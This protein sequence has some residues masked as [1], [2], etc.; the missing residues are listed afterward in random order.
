M[1]T[2]TLSREDGRIGE[3]SRDLEVLGRILL[4]AI[5]VS[6]GV[7]KLVGWPAV[8]GSIG[9]KGVPFPEIAGVA[10]IVLELCGALALVTGW[11]AR[12]A[13]V[14]LAVFTAAA[15]VL[16][17]PFWAVE[18]AQYMNQFNHFMK[19]VAIIGGLFIVAA[20]RR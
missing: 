11:G 19:N 10:V 20:R 1:Q 2:R 9:G 16:Y 12:W 18:A 7:A 3:T 13:A 17:H 5:F 15:S 4:A 14:A 6:S 8:V